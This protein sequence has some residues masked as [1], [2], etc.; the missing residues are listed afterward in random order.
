MFDY[1][2]DEKEIILVYRQVLNGER[3]SFPASWWQEDYG[4]VRALACT[5]Y[6]IQYLVHKE[7]TKLT[8]T[9]FKKYKLGGMLNWFDSKNDIINMVLPHMKTQNKAS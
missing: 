5:K 1:T 4:N 8:K 3:S 9:D 2:I 6:L 7:P